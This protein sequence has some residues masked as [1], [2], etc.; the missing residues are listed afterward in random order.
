M[1]LLLKNLLNQILEKDDW[2]L[3]LARQWDQVVGSLK[4]RIRLEKIYNDTLV[5][6]V[7]E[8]HWMQELYLLSPELRQKVNHF[9]QED[10]ITHIRFKLVEEKKRAPS[11]PPPAPL[12]R[13][14]KIV[15]TSSQKKAL[16]C[17]EDNHLK[18]SLID[19]WGRC[20][21]DNQ[22]EKV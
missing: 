18:E 13:P 12:V 8:Y 10:R 22:K 1:A 9:L 4:T 5:I 17:I 19:F 6:G 7:Y 21:A 16:K 14:E 3:N 15:L 11:K 20:L 2:R